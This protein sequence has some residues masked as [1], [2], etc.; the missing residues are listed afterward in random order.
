ML[1]TTSQLGQRQLHGSLGPDR[2]CDDCPRHVRSKESE[3][4]KLPIPS[5]VANQVKTFA[6]PL[7]TVSFCPRSVVPKL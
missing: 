5:F 3:L 4:A 7:E 6:F 2:L 1:H